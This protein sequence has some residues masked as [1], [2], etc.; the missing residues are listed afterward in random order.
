MIRAVPKKPPLDKKSVIA[1]LERAQDDQLLVRVR[2]W[3]PEADV[4][5]GFV[6][7]LGEKWI[8]LQR[9][10][11]RIAFDGWQLMRLK[12]VQ[13]V[14]LEPD[15]DNFEI[16][17]LK[18]RNQWPPTGPT[19]SLDDTL[20]A[21]NSASAADPMISIF[22]EFARPDVCW[23]GTIRS[24]GPDKISFLEVNTRGG[25]ARKPRTVDPADVTRIDLGGGYEEALQIV[26]G[27]A[28]SE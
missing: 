9:L 6:V 27:P 14:S 20:G 22:D 26:A 18:R 2:R 13:A 8:A 24:L 16:T 1:R 3:I 10:S 12:D 25:W 19:L 28:P 21:L 11:D 4:L 15:R 7:G 23:I 5:E 17:V